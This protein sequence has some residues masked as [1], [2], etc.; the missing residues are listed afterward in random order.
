MSTAYV[1]IIN[2]IFLKA[3][4]EQ[5]IYRYIHKSQQKNKSKIPTQSA[6]N[7]C[8][9]PKKLMKKGPTLNSEL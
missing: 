3:E 6:I 7:S 2:Q 5:Q 8:E 4:I 9:N 1:R